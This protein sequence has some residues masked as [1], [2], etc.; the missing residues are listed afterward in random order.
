VRWI[1]LI[2]VKACVCARPYVRFA[3]CVFACVR[4]V[5]PV[6]VS[7][8]FSISNSVC[9]FLLLGTFCMSAC[10][11]SQYEYKNLFLCPPTTRISTV[12]SPKTSNIVQATRIK[13]KTENKNPKRPIQPKKKRRKE[14]KSGK[15]EC[16]LCEQQEAEPKGNV[17]KAGGVG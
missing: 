14:E 8:F 11:L 12:R 9:F 1:A 4:V 13:R 7:L 5:A 3:V 17:K 2:G 10:Q 15:R 6:Y 16:G